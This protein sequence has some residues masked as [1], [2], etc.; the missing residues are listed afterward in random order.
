MDSSTSPQVSAPVSAHV[1][2]SAASSLDNIVPTQQLSYENVPASEATK[3]FIEV[4]SQMGV[5]CAGILPKPD[6]TCNVHAFR[7]QVEFNAYAAKYKPRCFDYNDVL[8][9]FDIKG[10][11][12][13]ASKIADALSEI[14]GEVTI[15]SY[16][17]GKPDGTKDA[18]EYKIIV[19]LINNIIASERG[20]PCIISYVESTGKLP[21]VWDGS[22]AWILQSCLSHH[23]GMRAFL[24]DDKLKNVEPLKSIVNATGIVIS[25]FTAKTPKCWKNRIL[26]FFR[27]LKHVLPERYKTQRAFEDCLNGWLKPQPVAPPQEAQSSAHMGC[28][29]CTF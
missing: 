23:P 5:T 24:V 17:G 20:V 29:Y 21:A 15:L 3:K 2:A 26:E 16:I 1:S 6:G 22:K 27:V 14:F 13:V 11:P 9:S 8:N 25:R 28:P 4:S 19:E 7:T 10:K 18:S 12:S